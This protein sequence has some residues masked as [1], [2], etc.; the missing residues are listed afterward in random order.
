M[1]DI[2]DIYWTVSSSRVASY[3]Q[4][5]AR[6]AAQFTRV[7]V[8]VLRRE[9][10]YV[11][12]AK[13]FEFG[14][15]WGKNL[16][17]LRALGCRSLYGV[18]ISKEQVDLSRRLGLDAVRL[19]SKEQDL[20]VDVGNRQF[21]LVLAIDVLE[22]M[23]LE[24]IERFAQ[25]TNI[26]LRPGGILVVQVPNDLAPLNPIRSG[27]L[28]HLRAFTGTSVE[29]FFKLCKLELI[30]IRGIGFPGSGLGYKIRHIIN[31][32]FLRPAILLAARI[33]YGRNDLF[34]IFEPNI[35]GLAKR[36]GP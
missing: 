26:L 7:M 28:T 14:A 34:G 12:D 15:G 31:G 16:L 35:L 18:D 27:D 20:L 2:Y 8:P 5:V 19:V 24:Q 13:I 11:A 33:M 36:K 1:S 3:S 4:E 17:A 6:T 30:S 29:Q 9:G 21:D 23:T 32:V 22:H 10:I 25:F